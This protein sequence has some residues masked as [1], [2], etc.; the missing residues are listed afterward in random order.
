MHTPTRVSER[1]GCRR[2][3]AAGGHGETLHFL[4]RSIVQRAASNR[5]QLVVLVTAGETI[6]AASDE[7]AVVTRRHVTSRLAVLE[8][9]G[10][11]RNMGAGGWEVRDDFENVLR[12]MQRVADHQKTLEAYGVLMSDERLLDRG[13]RLAANPGRRRS[14]PRSRAGRSLRA[15]LPHARR[16]RGSGST[17]FGTPPKWNRPAAQGRLRTNSSCACAGCL[18]MGLPPLETEDLGRADDILK[19]RQHLAETADRLIK[20]GVVPVR[21]WLGRL[22]RQ[23]SGAV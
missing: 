16:H 10:L 19:N 5:E 18:W 22:A 3:R 7:P 23:I 21:G 6:S 12:A 15:Q 20:R 17:S 11:A 9:M 1:A 8:S 14:N 4:D 13:A 2:S